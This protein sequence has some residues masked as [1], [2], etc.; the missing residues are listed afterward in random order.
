VLLQEKCAASGAGAFP[1]NGNAVDPAADDDDVEMFTFQGP[2][3]CGNVVHFRNHAEPD[4][5]LT[6]LRIS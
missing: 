1:C 4:A 2:P 3:E 6:L 5:G